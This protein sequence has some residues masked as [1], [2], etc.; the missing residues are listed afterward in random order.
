MHAEP[1]TIAELAR[2]L[3]AR[4]I[5]AEA[6]TG[7]CLQRIADLNP[8][9]NAFI[10]VLADDALGQAR[11]ADA[12]IAAGRPP[13]PLHGIPISIK[14]LFDVAGTPTTAASN[15][16]AGHVAG[17]DATA[18]ARLR[19]AGAILIGKTNLHEFALGPTGEDSAYGPTRHPLDPTRLAGGSS[20]GSAASVA[21]GMAFASVG[22]DTGGSVRIPAAACGLVGLKPAIGEIP[23]DGVV[24]LSPTLDHVG[25]LCRSVG[26]AALLYDVRFFFSF[27]NLTGKSRF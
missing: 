16:R 27:Y 11:A 18:V 4:D 6:V 14:D 12:S 17:R 23:T 1:R 2:A 26:D 15:V 7:G 24:P 5:T 10:T 9:I 25:P 13:G 22:T 19:D 8:A 20:G 3:R 21:S